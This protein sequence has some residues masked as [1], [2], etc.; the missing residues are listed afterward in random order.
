[1]S[2]STQ[3]EDDFRFAQMIATEAQSARRRKEEK[4]V[5]SQSDCNGRDI[6][7]NCGN[8]DRKL[9]FNLSKQ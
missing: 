7:L 8:I 9:N 4:R 1:M 6:L 5:C 3:R 2:C